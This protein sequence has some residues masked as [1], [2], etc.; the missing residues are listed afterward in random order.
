MKQPI[1][2][3]ITPLRH[4]PD[5]DT[6]P[7]Q[8]DGSQ[9]NGVCWVAREVYGQQNPDWQHFRQWL[10]TEAP[11]WF[12]S[13][14]IARGEATA[15]WLRDKPRVKSLIRRWMDRRIARRR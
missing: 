11:A 10:L 2:P 8:D 9:T 15:F 4:S 12:R 14:Y 6:A 7:S 5:T 13:L 1:I 3:S